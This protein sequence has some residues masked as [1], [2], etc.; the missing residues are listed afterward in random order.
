MALL[1]TGITALTNRMPKVIS[2]KAHAIIDYATA[3]SFLLTGALLWKRN[4]RAAIGSMVCG[5]ME[6]QTAMIT[7]FPGGIT[8]LISFETHGKI[9]AGFA[10]FVG[11]LPSLLAFGDEPEANFF[12]GQALAIAAVTGLTDFDQSGRSR[13]QRRSRSRRRAA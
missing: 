2:P 12:R 3:G 5:I 10:G 1:H 8:P 7:D 6:A 13:N 9:D 11:T 4:R